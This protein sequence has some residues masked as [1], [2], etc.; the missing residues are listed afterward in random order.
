MEEEEV[1]VN[2]E[3]VGEEEVDNT[4]KSNLCFHE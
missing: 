4:L 2:T 1:D 3:D